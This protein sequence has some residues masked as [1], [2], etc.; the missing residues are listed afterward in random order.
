MTSQR[1]ATAV[2][3]SWASRKV[4]Q[5]FRDASIFGDFDRVRTD[6][7][8]HPELVYE[9]DEHGF[10]ALHEVVGEHYREMA[11]LLITAG[12][13]VNAQNDEGI[14]PLH[15]AAYDFMAEILLKHGADINLKSSTGL[16][17]LHVKAENPEGLE[18][19]RTLLEK[20]AD[21]NAKSDAG[22]TALDVAIA[23]EEVDKVELMRQRGAN[24]QQ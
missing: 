6:L 23:R 21:V 5:E 20:G 19:M 13:D 4:D 8:A 3:S 15:L 24:A 7:A 14:G 12:A 11:E 16:T 1:A 17:P 10:T 22:E 9:T 2:R 18:V